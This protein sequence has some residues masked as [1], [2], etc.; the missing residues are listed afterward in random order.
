M[1]RLRLFSCLLFVTLLSNF[2]LA[3]DDDNSM[4]FITDGDIPI[5]G[6]AGPILEMSDISGDL[7][8][9]GGVGAGILFYRNFYVGGYGM[10]LINDHRYTFRADS[11]LTLGYQTAGAWLGYLNRSNDIVHIGLST[12]LGWGNMNFDNRLGNEVES[13]NLFLVTPQLEI[14]VNIAPFVKVNFGAGVRL[15]SGL[16]DSQFYNDDDFSSPVGSVSLLFGWFDD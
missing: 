16:D 15:V 1:K 11:T 5:S 3:Q 7:A 14:E 2:A 4:K 9:S 8:I 10:Q 6:F 12:K 13:S